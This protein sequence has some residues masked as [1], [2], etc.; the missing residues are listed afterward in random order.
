VPPEPQQPDPWSLRASDA[1]RDKYLPLLRE[2]DA[3]GRLDAV[4]YEERMEQ[5]LGAK[6]YRDLYP[7]LTDLPIDPTRVPGPP[8]MRTGQMVPTGQ[9]APQGERYMPVAAPRPVG[10]PTGYLPENSVVSIFGSTSRSGPW[11]VPSELTVLSVFGDTT[12]N[13]TGAILSGM[14]TELRCNAVFGSVKVIVPDALHLE[15]NGA[16]ILGEFETK[17]KRKGQ[18]RRRTPAPNAPQVR[19]TGT[20]LFGSVEVRVVVPKAG[21][22]VSMLNPALPPAPQHPAIERPPQPPQNPPAES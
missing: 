11:P 19:I 7:V 20:A 21:A 13:L 14:T 8:I 6:T 3:E 9:P 22:T 4:E 12:I 16:G 1:D 18:D 17:D 2:A 10:M 5:A 15:V